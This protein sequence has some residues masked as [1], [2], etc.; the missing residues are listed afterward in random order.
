MSLFG[1]LFQ[2]TQTSQQTSNVSTT[3]GDNGA[4]VLGTGASGNTIISGD[5]AATQAAIAGGT[6]VALG[7][8][9]SN[10]DVSLGAISFSTGAITNLA[11]MYGQGLAKSYG[12][13][14]DFANSSLTATTQAEQA[15]LAQT[16]NLVAAYGNLIGENTPGSAA[17]AV[18][19]QTTSTQSSTVIIVAIAIVALYLI[20]KGG[21]K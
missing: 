14:L 9:Q 19:K 17:L 7:A 2:T 12:N 1:S 11:D 5:A 15:A 4:V 10:T 13:A 18:E 6:Q 21:L 20:T 16:N 8:L 3:A